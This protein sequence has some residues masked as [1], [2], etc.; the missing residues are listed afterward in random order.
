MSPL[1]ELAIGAVGMPLNMAPVQ[2]A[3]SSGCSAFQSAV[4]C[5]IPMWPE[6]SDWFT[7][8]PPRT[9]GK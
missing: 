9:S 3:G 6:M 1:V 5:D 4:S 2:R 8:L 7:I